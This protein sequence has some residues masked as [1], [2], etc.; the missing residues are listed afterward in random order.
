MRTISSREFNRD[1][2]AAKRAADH[3]PVVITDRGR[4]SHV[5]LAAVAY[6]DLVGRGRLVGDRLKP[7]GATVEFDL[8][9]RGVDDRRV[10]EL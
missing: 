3:E 7:R 4:E 8:P 6:D 2:S 5:L 1:V 10:P 9:E